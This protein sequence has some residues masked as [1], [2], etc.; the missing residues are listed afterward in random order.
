MPRHAARAA[1]RKTP[2]YPSHV[3]AARKRKAAPDRMP[4]ERYTTTAYQTSVRSGIFKA[5]ARRVRVAGA[6][7]VT[8][9]A[10]T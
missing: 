3:A 9:A 7:Y 6:L 1:A 2:R 4:G 8:S 10:I 5:N